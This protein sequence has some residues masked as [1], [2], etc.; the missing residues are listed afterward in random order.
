[1]NR[2]CATRFPVR[3]FGLVLLAA[4]ATMFTDARSAFGAK[5]QKADPTTARPQ[6]S[7]KVKIYISVDM[8][9]IA[10]VVTAD[11]LGPAGFE[12]ERF[13]RFMTNEALAA[14]PGA[15]AAGAR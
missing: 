15:R 6:S 4:L 7:K 5:P 1:M 13:R 9:G 2:I 11:Q 8:E 12:Y 14:V 3:S 10:G